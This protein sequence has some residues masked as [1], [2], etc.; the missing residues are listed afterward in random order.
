MEKMIMF[1]S[2]QNMRHNNIYIPGMVDILDNIF[3][4]PNALKRDWME[5]N[6]EPVM[7]WDVFT[8][9]HVQRVK[10][11]TVVIPG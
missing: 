9:L 4:V 1:F 5:G 6:N 8:T 10:S 7:D 11:R 3:S 2:F